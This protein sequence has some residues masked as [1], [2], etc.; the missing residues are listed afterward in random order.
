MA[1][2]QGQLI[3]AGE[4]NNVN[5][6]VPYYYAEDLRNRT[7]ASGYFPFEA[8]VFSHRTSASVV[9][10]WRFTCGWWGGVSVY[11]QKHNGSGYATIATLYSG[12][13][14]IGSFDVSGYGY[15]TGPGWYRFYI[16]YS[17][18]PRAGIHS[19]HNTCQFGDYLVWYDNPQN[20]GNR[21][22]DGTT[23]TASALNSGRVGTIPIL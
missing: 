13:F 18:N 14:G 1:F 3:T 16:T 8:G 19:G 23:L 7:G 21:I 15:S 12:S 4:L 22:M 9:G 17:G 11:L 20:S 10:Y 6:S 5:G 2:I